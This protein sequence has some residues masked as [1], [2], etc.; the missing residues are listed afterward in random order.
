MKTSRIKR[1]VRL[2]GFSKIALFIR[3]TF[4]TAAALLDLKINFHKSAKNRIWNKGSFD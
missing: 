4:T 2:I 1:Q 3:N